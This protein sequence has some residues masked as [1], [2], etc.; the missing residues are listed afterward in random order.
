MPVPVLTPYL[1]SLWL[2][3]VTPLYARVGRKLIEGVAHITVVQ[4]KRALQVFSVQPMGIE[5]VMRF[6]MESEMPNKDV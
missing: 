6:A 1:S 4:D 5:D 3:I 2:G